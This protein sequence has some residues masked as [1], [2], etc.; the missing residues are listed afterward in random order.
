M[1]RPGR[2]RSAQVWR[3][4]IYEQPQFLDFFRAVTPIDVI[5]RMQIGSHS[6]AAQ[7]ARR[8]RRHTAGALGARLVAVAAHAAGLVWSRAGLEFA[9]SERGIELLRRC[10][11]GWPFF[12]S[13][14]DDIEAMLARADLGVAAH[15]DRLAPP[16]LRPT[17]RSCGRN[18][19]AA[20]RWCWRSRSA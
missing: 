11:R 9:K 15:Y 6:G 20:A 4:L 19:S 18:T 14:I 3:G 2:G 8:R 12:H 5:E 17:A 13:L 1:C 16:E 10:Y 7:R